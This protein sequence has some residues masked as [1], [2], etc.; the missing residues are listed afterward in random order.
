MAENCRRILDITIPPEVVRKREEAITAQFQRH[1]RLP[2]FR[3]GK[4]P[5]SLIQRKFR[6]DI[7]SQV[8]Q[9]LVPEYV[10]AQAREQQWETVGAPSV[11][12]V[13][14]AENSALRF[15]ATL[16]VLPEFVVQDYTGLPIEVAEP[17]VSDEEVDRAL[18]RLREQS[19]TYVNLDP[20]PLQEGDYASISV[21]G[22]SPG[23]DSSGVHVE[24]VLC[25]IGGPRTVKEFT[26]NLLGA[27]VGEE[28]HFDVAYPT[29]FGDTR[30]AGKTVSYQAKVLGLKK[31]YLPEL[32]D[33]FARE[34]GNFESLEAVR[35]HVRDDLLGARLRDAEQKAKSQVRQKLAQLHEFPVP[36]T[37]VERQLDRRLERLRRQLTAQG[38]DPQTLALDWGKIRTSQRE[39]ARE[40]VKC[41]LV[42][43]RITRQE[44]VEVSEVELERELQRIAAV[45]D[46]TPAAVRARLTKEG[47]LDKVT[48]ALRIEK[49]LEFVFQSA[50]R[51]VLPYTQSGSE[52]S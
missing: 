49:A 25:E 37:L 51:T 10:E 18:E 17:Q 13:E 38:M 15:K 21:R 9:D 40:D 42:L 14:Y 30:L 19:A 3:P 28:R 29:D 12:E 45:T 35:R 39:A 6:D 32:N 20:R 43:E 11:T 47:K 24:E 8:L 23:K 2:G 34:L 1:A 50:Q 31:K 52:S 46:Q 7:R 33:D 48:S 5:A 22:T 27:Q 36:E 44:N 26:E 41:N 4:A 16:E